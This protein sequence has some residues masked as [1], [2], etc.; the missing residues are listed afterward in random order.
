MGIQHSAHSCV[1][2]NSCEGSA[3][4]VLLVV[5]SMEQLSRS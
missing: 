1:P 4:A 3:T 5:Y 2:Q